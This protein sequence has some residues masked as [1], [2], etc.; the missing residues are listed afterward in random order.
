VFPVPPFIQ[1]PLSMLRRLEAAL[2]DLLESVL[3]TR[4]FPGKRACRLAECAR[5]TMRGPFTALPVGK[6]KDK[7][8]RTVHFGNKK[9]KIACTSWAKHHRDADP[10]C[11]TNRAST[12]ADPVSPNVA[13]KGGA[14]AV[15]PS[16]RPSG[17]ARQQARR[18]QE[19]GVSTAQLQLRWTDTAT[20]G[21]E[22]G[23]SSGVTVGSASPVRARDS[24][25]HDSYA[26]WALH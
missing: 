4:F 13:C 10:R 11:S 8:S 12:Q 16:D 25:S 17:A 6:H 1:N 3:E 22:C 14:A 18:K 21:C 15:T 24:S 2:C 26:E 23:T 20:K 9:T 5:A 7:S 19:L